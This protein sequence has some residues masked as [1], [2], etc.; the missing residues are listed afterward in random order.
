MRA[1]AGDRDGCLAGRALH[2]PRLDP[3]T[4]RLPRRR[5][6]FRLLDL[7]L[8]LVVTRRRAFVTA[9]LQRPIAHL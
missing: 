4:D 3:R 8:D 6:L 2:S 5:G 9:G 1:E 7:D